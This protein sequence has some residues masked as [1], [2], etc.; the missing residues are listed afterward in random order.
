[1]CRSAKASR[2]PR[3]AFTLVEVMCAMAILVFIM[4]MLSQILGS[5]TQAWVG[6]QRKANNFT[7]ARVMLEMFARDIRGGVFR[8]D[9][10]AFPGGQLSLYTNSQGVSSQG[11]SVRAVSLVTYSYSTDRSTLAS[12]STLQRGDTGILWSSDAAS[13]AFGNT[14]G[15]GANAVHPRDTAAGVIAYKAVFLYADGTLSSTYSAGTSSPVS[16][17]GTSSAN[18]LCG[19]GLTLAV[20]DDQTLLQLNSAQF[21]GLRSLL[22]EGAHGTTSVKGDW[23]KMIKS[24]ALNGYPMGV[25]ANLKIFERYVTLPTL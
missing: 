20:I 25:K 24:G 7:K 21:L 9:L 18:P 17:S 16:S 2:R 6:G 5:V 19:V 15:F 8:S 22:E 4:V 12:L 11:G 13:I 10:A 14:A 1:M 3:A 23:E